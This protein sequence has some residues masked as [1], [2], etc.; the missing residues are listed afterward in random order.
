MFR[1]FFARID[2]WLDAAVGYIQD[3]EPDP[4]LSPRVELPAC[5]PR[6]G[7][8]R[9]RYCR[10]ARESRERPILLP[11][12]LETA[13]EDDGVFRTAVDGISRARDVMLDRGQLG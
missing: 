5:T 7:E 11:D 1:Y 4:F 9:E 10:R 12:W 6:V 8:T 13:A 2:G 3:P